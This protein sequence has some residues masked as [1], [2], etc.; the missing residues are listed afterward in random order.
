MGRFL[1]GAGALLLIAGVLVMLGEKAG[2]RPGH[3]PG[4]IR[5]EGKSGGFY[6]PLTTCLIISGILSLLSW[7][8]RR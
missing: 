6:F 7:L 5:I 2:I 4:D 1:V 3:L 8:F